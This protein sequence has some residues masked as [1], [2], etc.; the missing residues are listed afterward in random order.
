[1]Q[2]MVSKLF[3]FRVYLR[4]GGCKFFPCRVDL[5]LEGNVNNF[6]NIDYL[7]TAVAINRKKREA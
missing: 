7:E 3:P 5:V 6:D 1:M 4:G 2:T